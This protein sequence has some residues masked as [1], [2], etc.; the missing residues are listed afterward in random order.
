MSDAVTR[1]E[2]LLN[3]IATGEVVDI[4][5]VTRKEKYLRYLAGIGEKP[6]KPI[7]REEMLLDKIQAGG[8]GGGGEEEASMLDSLIQGTLEGVFTS[9]A[10]KI[11]KY[12][13]CENVSITE[14]Y[15]PNATH[16]GM[17][18]FEGCT[19][20][21]SV[22]L[23]NVIYAEN[24]AFAGSYFTTLSLPNLLEVNSYGFKDSSVKKLYI[25]NVTKIGKSSFDTSIEIVDTSA[26]KSIAS[27]AF[28]FSSK[29]NLIIRN[30]NDIVTLTSN[31][32]NSSAYCYVPRSF[33]ES[34][35]LAT[36]WSNYASQIRAL[37]DYTVDGTITGELDESKI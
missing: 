24:Y 29:L 26:L 13:L 8:T 16:L 25:E 10:S 34:Y 15:F 35:Q 36:N 4:V 1:E 12:A 21:L 5:P 27:T 23:P 37:E 32:F 18:C 9:N 22:H 28:Q 2:T 19:N 31:S 17:R 30:E 20:L 11:K 14:A 6:S 7:T 33:V 3:A